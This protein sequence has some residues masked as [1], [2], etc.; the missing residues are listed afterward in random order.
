MDIGVGTKLPDCF[1]DKENHRLKVSFGEINNSREFAIPKVYDGYV[2]IDEFPTKLTRPNGKLGHMT[3]NVDDD[4]KEFISS[5]DIIHITAYNAYHDSKVLKNKREKNVN[6]QYYYLLIR[7]HE[8]VLRK[9]IDRHRA[10]IVIDTYKDLLKKDKDFSK[11]FS[12]MEER[13]RNLENSEEGIE[14]F[15]L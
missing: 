14:K 13:V 4:E 11:M 7:F 10:T 12:E 1:Y 2:S 3:V 9:K 5:E 15:S 8:F 6:C